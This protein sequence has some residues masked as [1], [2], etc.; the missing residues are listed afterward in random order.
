MLSPANGNGRCGTQNDG[1]VYAGNFPPSSSYSTNSYV[2]DGTSWTTNPASLSTGRNGG[3][4]ATSSGSSG[5]A[6]LA[7]GDLSETTT[8]VN[9]EEFTA[10]GP[11]TQTITTS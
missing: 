5:G 10:A 9:T 11:V 6:F 8:Y 7:G 3:G 1:M 2:Y 4:P